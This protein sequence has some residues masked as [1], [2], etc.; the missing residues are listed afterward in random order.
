MLKEAVSPG[1][2]DREQEQRSVHIS[3]PHKLGGKDVSVL[4]F[5]DYKTICN[6]YA[7]YCQPCYSRIREFLVFCSCVHLFNRLMLGAHYM[8]GYIR[9][10]ALNKVKSLPSWG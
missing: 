4:C 1:I 7:M 9:D 3:H 5:L 2:G 6:L 10:T 8:Q